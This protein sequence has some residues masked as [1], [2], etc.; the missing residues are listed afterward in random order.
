MNHYKITYD[1][2]GD[3]PIIWILKTIFLYIIV[4][5]ELTAGLPQIL[6]KVGHVS[7]RHYLNQIES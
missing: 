7:I 5:H 6:S 4:I 1:L 3:L 2:L